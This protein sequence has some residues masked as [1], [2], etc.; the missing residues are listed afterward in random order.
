MN[1]FLNSQRIHIELS[2]AVFDRETGISEVTIRTDYGEFTGT[3]KMHP[4]DTP[5]A[6]EFTGCGLAERRA[7][8]KYIKARIRECNA[9]IKILKHLADTYKYMC[10]PDELDNKKLYWKPFDFIENLRQEITVWK[11]EMQMVDRD[12]AESIKI[13]DKITKR[14]NAVSTNG[15]N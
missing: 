7:Y 5:Y 6:S 9:Q 1:N 2:K 10:N 12:I 3:A 11:E 13:R 8:K 4:D 15:Q 14:L